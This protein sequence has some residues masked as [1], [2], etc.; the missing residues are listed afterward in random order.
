MAQNRNGSEPL[1]V[2]IRKW[3]KAMRGWSCGKKRLFFENKD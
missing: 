2:C 3:E 1:L